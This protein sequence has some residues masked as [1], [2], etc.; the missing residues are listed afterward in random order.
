MCRFAARTKIIP[1]TRVPKR[2]LNGNLMVDG[3]KANHRFAVADADRAS[4]GGAGAPGPGG[5]QCCYDPD[6]R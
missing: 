1:T 6:H 2:T 3:A 4:V 5:C